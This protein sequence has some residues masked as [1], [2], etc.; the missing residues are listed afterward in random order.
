MKSLITDTARLLFPCFCVLCKRPLAGKIL[1]CRCTP[2]SILD[3]SEQ[4][5]IRCFSPGQSFDASHT[6]ELCRMYPS[7]FQEIRY[8]WEYEGRAKELISY[9]KYKPSVAVCGLAISKIDTTSALHF[10][11]ANFDLIVPI[12]ATAWSI[13]TRGF[14]PCDLI[15][16]TLASRVFPGARF[17]RRILRNCKRR[18][19]QASLLPAKRFG[20]V[21]NSFAAA[22]AVQGARVLLVDDVMTTGATS[23]SAAKALL[24]A[25]AA[26]VSLFVLARSATFQRFRAKL[27]ACHTNPS[28]GKAGV[29]CN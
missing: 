16:R 13:L 7:P 25:G 24:D 23:S 20:N 21:R 19:P 10:L 4:R 14:A 17:S 26:T 1:C 22:K 18:R 3:E 29:L 5:C 12:P 9:F 2:P 6:C 8:F 28:T 11:D 27:S 15:G